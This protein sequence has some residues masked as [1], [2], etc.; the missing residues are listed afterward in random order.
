MD[1][2]DWG[3][4][5]GKALGVGLLIGFAYLAIWLWGMA[6]KAGRKGVEIGRSALDAANA[7]LQGIPDSG[8]RFD[9]LYSRALAEVQAK[10]FDAACWAKALAAA[11][12]DEKKTDALYIKYRVEQL[13][14]I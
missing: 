1:S 11:V 6:T 12:G 4:I 2:L 3:K 14:A 5:V 10:N 8:S 9:D 13:K 7:Q